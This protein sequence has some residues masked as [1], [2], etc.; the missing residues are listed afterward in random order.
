ML[1]IELKNADEVQ[2]ELSM[3]RIN[4]EYGKKNGVSASKIISIDMIQIQ[5]DKNK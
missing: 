4:K 2:V 5:H 1:Y 3:P